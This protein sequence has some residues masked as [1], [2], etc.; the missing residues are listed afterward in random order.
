MESV[1]VSLDSPLT[2]S[3]GDLFE[4][5]LLFLVVLP[6]SHQELGKN[7]KIL[8]RN[9]VLARSNPPVMVP[10][11]HMLPIKNGYLPEN[12][13]VWKTDSL[14]PK[15]CKYFLY[16][17]DKSGQKVENVF[18]LPTEPLAILQD[19]RVE[20]DPVEDISAEG[21]VSAPQ[22]NLKLNNTNNILID[23]QNTFIKVQNLNSGSLN[24]TYPT[25]PTGSI[26]ILD[27]IQDAPG[28]FVP[29]Y[30]ANFSDALTDINMTSGART[31]QMFRSDGVYWLRIAYSA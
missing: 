2:W 10:M 7:G 20:I 24:V 3:D 27:L 28:D 6:Q 1:K 5:D 9:P 17:F 30:D 13:R 11:W 15:G 26:L 31:S 21:V 4:G 16:L 29:T 14:S 8:A 25:K 18:T 23:M 19:Y 22:S 12:S